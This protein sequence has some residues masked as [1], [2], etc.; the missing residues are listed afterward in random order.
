MILREPDVK[1]HGVL[2]EF[3]EKKAKFPLRYR[4]DPKHAAVRCVQVLSAM[5][6]VLKIGA[7]EIPSTKS[8]YFNS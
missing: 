1:L 7:T 8:G 2:L 5:E 6:T 4:F 3:P